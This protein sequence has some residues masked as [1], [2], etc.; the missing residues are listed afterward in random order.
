MVKAVLDVTGLGYVIDVGKN[1]VK[2]VK[3]PTKIQRKKTDPFGGEIWISNM[4]RPYAPT[5]D[6]GGDSEDY[7]TKSFKKTNYRLQ[8]KQLILLVRLVFFL[9]RRTKVA[10]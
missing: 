8:K 5:V 2:G 6:T 1:V 10:E 9:S 7:S 3:Q 4:Y